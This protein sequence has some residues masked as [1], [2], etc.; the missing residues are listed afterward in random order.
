MSH[1]VVAIDRPSRPMR[2]RTR[3]ESSSPAGTAT[4]REFKDV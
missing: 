3:L 4:L 2:K 1:I